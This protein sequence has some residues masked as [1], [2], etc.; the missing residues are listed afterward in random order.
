MLDRDSVGIGVEIRQ[1]LILGDP[2]T[3]NLV[4]DNQLPGFVIDLEVEVLAE[5]GERYFSA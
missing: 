4:S 3:V 5:I 1:G 2:A